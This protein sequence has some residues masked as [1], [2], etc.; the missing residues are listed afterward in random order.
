[1]TTPT[2]GDVLVFRPSAFFTEAERYRLR[3]VRIPQT[4]RGTVIYVNEPHRFYTVE[5]ECNGY[6]IRES[7]KFDFET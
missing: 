5:A 6:I 7:F 3:D 4:L 2:I 1:M